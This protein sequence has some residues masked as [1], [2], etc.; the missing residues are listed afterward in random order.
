MPPDLHRAIFVNRDIV[1]RS[2]PPNVD[3]GPDRQ[4][5]PLNG[6]TST[7]ILVDVHSVL[8][9]S[10]KLQQVQLSQLG[11]RDKLLKPHI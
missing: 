4:R 7:S 2:Q 8:R 5:F 6:P 3:F 11:P 10:L 1:H 9:E